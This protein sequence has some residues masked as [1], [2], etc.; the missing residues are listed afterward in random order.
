M[1]HLKSGRKLNR[2]YTHRKALLNNLVTALLEHKRINTTEAKAKE[3]RPFVEAVITRA[4]NAVLREQNGNLPEG[5]KIDLHA[6]RVVAKTVKTKAVLQEL[7]DVIAPKVADRP[8]GYTRVIKTNFRRGD[9]GSAAIIEL[10][11]FAADR[12]VAVTIN[13]ADKAARQA[14]VD[15]VNARLKNKP[16]QVVETIVEPIAEE[17]PV[18][19]ETVVAEDVVDEAIA[20]ETP[21]IEN[22]TEED[23]TSEESENKSV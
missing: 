6:R 15:E 12:T 3:L 5:S 20:T 19:E 11:D 9:G 10:V 16:V 2:T 23:T 8:G 14:K 17:I 13:Q 18:V 21:N 22:N 4:K 1:R 7:F